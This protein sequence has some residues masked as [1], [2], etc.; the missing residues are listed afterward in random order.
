[1]NTLNAKIDC[2]KESASI[3]FGDVSHEFN[4]S[5]FLRQP[6]DKEF[7]SKDESTGLASTVV[8]PTDLL[9]QYLLDHE[10]VMFMNERRE[11]DE[12]FFKQE[13][14]LKS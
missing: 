10:N 3:Y 2:T 1:M 9:E 14:I 11:I 7:P 6:H 8:P 4:F 12:V 5:K 13:P